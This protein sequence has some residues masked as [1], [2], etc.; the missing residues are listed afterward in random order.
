[1]LKGKRKG[2]TLVE[3]IVSIAVLSIMAFIVMYLFTEGF[4]I[5]IV[6]RN[7]IKMRTDGRYALSRITYEIREAEEIAVNPDDNS[8]TIKSDVDNDGHPERIRY[9]KT[10]SLLM[11]GEEVQDGFAEVM[12]CP[13]ITGSVFIDIDNMHTCVTIMLTLSVAN[14]ELKLWTE[15]TKRC[16]TE[17]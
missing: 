6:N 1:M 11:R 12:L 17:I 10:G 14:E 16:G 7:Y 15:A 4:K 2:F 13:N 5:Y 8:I 9:R 3:T